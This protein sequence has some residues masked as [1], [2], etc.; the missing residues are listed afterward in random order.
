MNFVKKCILA[1]LNVLL[2]LVLICGFA[3]IA[4]LIY[5]AIIIGWNLL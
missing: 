3:I 4:K 2:T 5:Y 1:L